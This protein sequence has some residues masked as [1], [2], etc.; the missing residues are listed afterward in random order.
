VPLGFDYHQTFV[1]D[2]SLTSFG[3]SPV[4]AAAYWR[5]VEARVRRIPGVRNAALTTLPPFGNRVTVNAERT[6]FYH[7]TP[8]Y[9]DTMRIALKRGRLFGADESGVLLVS[10]SLARRRWPDGDAI[11]KTYEDA[12][13]VG[14]VADAQTVR[15]GEQGATECYLAIRPAQLS[16]AVMV[17]RVG[18]APRGLASTIRAAMRGDDAR[19]MP[20]VVL[21]EDALQ[22]RLE[23]PRQVALIASAIGFCALLLAVTGLGGMIAFT[24]SQRL[25]EIGVR[26]ALGARPAHIVRAIARQF[27]APLLCGAAAGSALAALAGTILSREMFG[28]SNLD[29]LAHGGALL[30]F[31]AVTA[32]AVLPSIRRALRVDPIQTLRHE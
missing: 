23:S 14:V 16:G 29:P 12:T 5:G 10:E 18:G 25:R 26:L 28:V 27:K 13:I 8:A 30:L 17:V 31:A 15:V 1:A 3:T 6:I 7:V 24:V 20:S 22:D 2:P 19:L 11:G 32:V 4:A 9:F 21:L